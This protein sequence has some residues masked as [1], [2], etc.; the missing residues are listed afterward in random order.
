MIRRPPRSTLFPYTTLFRS[1][2]EE[3]KN[4]V[5]NGEV[6][7]ETI[8]NIAD[9]VQ[10][11]KEIS[12]EKTLAIYTDKVSEINK[13]LSDRKDA[14]EAA[15]EAKV[16][17]E[18]AKTPGEQITTTEEQTLFKGMQPKIK[19]GK[20]FSA[21]KIE[22]GEF[23]A[24]DKKLASDY[25]GD[26]PLKKFTVPPGTTIDV[27]KVEDTNQPLSEVKKQEEK[28][29][30]DSDAQVV[31]LITRD[32]RGTV[33]EQY[34]I[35]DDSIL[36]TAE[37]VV[38]EVEPEVE[39]TEEVKPEVVEDSK[40]KEAKSKLPQAKKNIKKKIGAAVDVGPLLDKLF[41]VN[42]N[43]VPKSV[44]NEYLEV[45]DVFSKKGELSPPEVQEVIKK[46]ENLLN[47]IGEQSIKEPKKQ[48]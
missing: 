40:I 47:E 37:D 34:I 35:K 1:T 16:E 11:G 30:D 45:L 22:K 17:L 10:E 12:D 29:I 13:I 15:P 3:Y 6:S 31:K 48:K 39:V 8:S 5:D 7:E 9:I 43:I 23:A 33:E 20:P 36:E 4:F 26:K 41:A 21:H 24:A 44:F 2:E 42:P 14:E 28:L 38:E 27:V 18:Q 19:D 46:A 25:K 32:A